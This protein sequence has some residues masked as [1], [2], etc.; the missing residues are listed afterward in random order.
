MIDEKREQEVRGP[1]DLS[2]RSRDGKPAVDGPTLLTVE[3][4]A[5]WLR[6]STR[7]VWRM[8]SSGKLPS[9]LR[10]GRVK[11]WTDVTIREWIAAGCP[12]RSEV[13]ARR[14]FDAAGPGLGRRQGKGRSP[15]P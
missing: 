12:S 1:Q 3:D 14:A 7:T 2:T 9:C 8:E 6:I 13:A 5:G 4:V 11:R 15:L 10:F